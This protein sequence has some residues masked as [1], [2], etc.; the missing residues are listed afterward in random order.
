M[1]KSLLC[2][3]AA[4][5]LAPSPAWADPGSDLKALV[6]DYWAYVL[7]ESPVMASSL[8]NDSYAGKL[9]DYSLAGMD[10]FAKASADYLKRLQAIDRKSVV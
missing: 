5:A 6:D 9:G 10:R 8:G 4:L 2:S 3:L 1:H 7:E